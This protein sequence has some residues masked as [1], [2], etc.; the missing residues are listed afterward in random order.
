MASVAPRHTLGNEHLLDETARPSQ[1]CKMSDD[2]E[3]QRIFVSASL[4]ED[5]PDALQIPNRKP[6]LDAT[7]VRSPSFTKK[8]RRQLSRKSFASSKPF[9]RALKAEGKIEHGGLRNAIAY[10]E[11]CGQNHVLETVDS[12]TFD[13][14]AH[15]LRLDDSCFYALGVDGAVDSDDPSVYENNTG[16]A[17]LGS[18]GDH[19]DSA[20]QELEL[21]PSHS[22]PDLKVIPTITMAGL[23]SCKTMATSNVDEEPGSPESDLPEIGS[24]WRFS[25]PDWLCPI[26]SLASDLS[27]A[28]EYLNM[29]Y[30]PLQR[31]NTTEETLQNCAMERV[32]GTPDEIIGP[33]SKATALG[34]LK[35]TDVTY[36]RSDSVHL[37]NMQ[38]SQHLRSQSQLSSATSTNDSSKPW[39]QRLL[40]HISLNSVV[41]SATGSGHQRNMPSIDSASPPDCAARPI[42]ADA[43][44][45]IYSRSQSMHDDQQLFLYD[46]SFNSLHNDSHVVDPPLERESDTNSPLQDFAIS[47]TACDNLPVV[48][49]KAYTVGSTSRSE[50]AG[51]YEDSHDSSAPA[52]SLS[53]SSS[54]GSL[55]KLSKFKEDLRTSLE[56]KATKKRRSLLHLLFPKLTREKL[57][58]LSTPLLPT[59]IPF[60]AL[61]DGPSDE[62]SLLEPPRDTTRD[63]VNRSVSFEQLNVEPPQSSASGSMLTSPGLSPNTQSL[64]DYER[65]LSMSGDDRRRKSV[66]SVESSKVVQEDDHNRSVT[67]KLNR[68]APL[69]GGGRKGADN[70]LMEKALRQHQLEKAALVRANRKISDASSNPV[71]APLFNISFGSSTASTLGGRSAALDDLDPLDAGSNTTARR[72]QSMQHLRSPAMSHTPSRPFAATNIM[73]RHTVNTQSHVSSRG[74]HRSAGHLASWSRF[75]SHTRSQR[76]G[77]AGQEDNVVHRDFAYATGQED[78][79]STTAKSTTPASSYG[80]I[81]KP[82]LLKKR[83]WIVRSRSL[84]FDTVFRYYSNLF[85]SSA[86]RNRRS[87][88]AIGGRLEH[89]E[90]EVLPPIFPAHPYGLPPHVN[91]SGRVT[92]FVDHLKEEGHHLKEEG[93]HLKE[94]IKQDAHDLLAYPRSYLHHS[95]LQKDAGPLENE[96]NKSRTDSSGDGRGTAS[97]CSSP[98]APSF[99]FENSSGEL[100]GNFDGAVDSLSESDEGMQRVLGARK[101]SQM[102]QAFVHL[103]NSLEEDREAEEQYQQEIVTGSSALSHHLLASDTLS[104]ASTEKRTASDTLAVPISACRPGD[105]GIIVRRFPSVTVMDDRKGHWRSISLISAKS[106]ISLRNSTNDLLDRIKESETIE[107]EKLM[108]VAENLGVEIGL[109]I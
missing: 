72:S 62:P 106:G 68:A 43:S 27:P 69:L 82:A 36:E 76:C 92:Q 58:S 51:S 104:K 91:S 29:T 78:R 90:L 45:S 77:S 60:S 95:Q 50:F 41:C 11:G 32:A 66:V 8:L 15:S 89:P 103:P 31:A 53:R 71:Q 61:Y 80:R 12:N 44:S 56:T 19:D 20:F 96:L 30:D 46:I 109:A 6:G 34:V 93:Q 23:P 17:C 25:L 52:C 55:G 67:R 14:D 5:H 85:T 86:A 18:D 48:G 65:H 22:N 3:L 28:N 54:S 35:S 10:D 87:S 59:T 74:R 84:T 81:S 39:N 83:N 42:I 47:S 70:I 102:Y 101:L 73:S 88:I 63:H 57:R 13:P 33:P 107:R 37:H 105:K 21:A 49:E 100:P 9:A 7:I 16:A 94:E 24:A 2:L 108:R 79:N 1:A 26:P 64:A 38:I 75:P 99:H 97:S 4:P 40:G 98:V